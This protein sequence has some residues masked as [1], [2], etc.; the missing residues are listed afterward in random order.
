MAY[1][2][3]LRLGLLGVGSASLTYNLDEVE[4][5]AVGALRFG[6]AVVTVSIL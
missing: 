3:L 6:R 1:R 4:T 5:A 2:T